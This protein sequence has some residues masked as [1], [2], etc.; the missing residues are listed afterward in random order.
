MIKLLLTW[1]SGCSLVFHLQTAAVKEPQFLE[2]SGTGREGQKICRNIT[3]DSNL[4]E[5][6]AWCGIQAVWI[7]N[8]YTCYRVELMCV[9]FCFLHLVFMTNSC[10]RPLSPAHKN[11]FPL[12]YVI[13]G[14]AL[15][16]P[17]Y[18]ISIWFYSY[19]EI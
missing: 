13:W 6:Q 19:P 15:F 17:R 7:E 12:A 14:S 9:F 1:R 4:R 8:V 11:S 3:N 5:V 18:R 10:A 16:E 2:R